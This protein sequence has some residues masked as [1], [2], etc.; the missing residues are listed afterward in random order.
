MAKP[1]YLKKVAQAFRMGIILSYRGKL[2]ESKRQVLYELLD[3]MAVALTAYGVEEQNKRIKRL[4]AVL[5]E[6]GDLMDLPIY[7]KR[8][9]RKKRRRP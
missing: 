9:M 8:S 1:I 6:L 5:G 2:R 3:D 7:S 4:A